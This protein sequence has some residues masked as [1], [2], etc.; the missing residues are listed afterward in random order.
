[1]NEHI[2]EKIIDD[3]YKYKI[4]EDIEFNQ[5]YLLCSSDGSKYQKYLI[6]CYKEGD[7]TKYV[8][9]PDETNLE[10]FKQI[11]EI[12]HVE[13]IVSTCIHSD[14]MYNKLIY[15]HIDDVYFIKYIIDD[16]FYQLFKLSNDYEIL[17]KHF[18]DKN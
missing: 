17:K 2:L 14:S 8:E 11:D 10:K 4:I 5:K 7:T 3:K 15:Y 16:E 12:Y 6:V 9:I 18:I 1:M 13:E